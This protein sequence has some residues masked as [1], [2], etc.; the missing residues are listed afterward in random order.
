[1]EA[2]NQTS[3]QL[4]G[5]EMRKLGK[6]D[7]EYSLINF[8]FILK[9]TLL[10]LVYPSSI[11]VVFAEVR[12]QCLHFNFSP[13]NDEGIEKVEKEEEPSRDEFQQSIA[14]GEEAIAGSGH[15]GDFRS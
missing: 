7:Q 5:G 2:S 6:L 9:F 14:S 4:K 3:I 1:L 13:Y 15:T 12:T 10:T 8:V 11:G